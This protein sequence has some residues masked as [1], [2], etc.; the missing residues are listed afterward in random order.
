MIDVAAAGEP[1]AGKAAD[2]ADII[3][4]AAASKPAAEEVIPCTS[5]H[6]VG[7]RSSLA[8][9]QGA[10]IHAGD[11]GC[12]GPVTIVSWE[13]KHDPLSSEG[14]NWACR[15]QRHRWRKLSRRA[16]RRCPRRPRRG[17]PR[18]PQQMA[19]FR[20]NC[21]RFFPDVSHFLPL[22]LCYK[23]LPLS[24]LHVRLLCRVQRT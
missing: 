10:G 18:M 12:P 13:Q 22:S 21:F 9:C 23:R 24:R 2:A 14:S 3:D 19:R 8:R 20:V 4:V 6:I 16:R 11:E 17:R 1:A 5:P 7:A 15:L